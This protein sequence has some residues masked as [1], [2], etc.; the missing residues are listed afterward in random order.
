MS[1]AT[2]DK[3]APER[4]GEPLVSVR[5]ITKVYEGP[6]EVRALDVPILDIWPGEMLAVT[7]P[8][9]SGKS[10][11][12][13]VLGLLT[14]ATSGSYVLAGHDVAQLSDRERTRRRAA[15]IGFVFQAFHLIAGRTALENV[16][17]G[18][19][20]GP[21]RSRDRARAATDILVRLGL[22]HRLYAR[23]ETL[24]G[25]EKQRVALARAV[26]ARPSLLLCDEPTGNLDSAATESVLDIIEELHRDG[27]TV[28]M[29]T[30]DDAVAAKAARRA[31]IEDGRVE[32]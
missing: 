20:Y 14:S 18:L 8:S 31:E 17:L 32:S 15:T 3:P 5:D 12:L 16:V 9:G 28:V 22:E 11:L 2:G 23:P 29:I 21:D 7:G 25:G 4:S 13:N 10:T 19:T 6:P 26:V 1:S 24:S 27:M 30:H